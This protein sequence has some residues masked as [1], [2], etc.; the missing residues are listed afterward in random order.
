MA[1]VDANVLVYC[2]VQRPIS[3][4][5]MAFV[6]G[7]EPLIAPSL[8]LIEVANTL[9]KYVRRGAIDVALARRAFDALPRLVG[10]ITDAQ[11]LVAPALQL[12]LVHAQSPADFIYVLLARERS[13]QLAT[14]DRKLIAKL[15]GTPY[16]NDVIDIAS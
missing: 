4:K 12:G 5:V 3:A 8:L 14:A 7:G 16:Q 10:E 13:T 11:H 9:A 15:A 6:A 1:V 2:F